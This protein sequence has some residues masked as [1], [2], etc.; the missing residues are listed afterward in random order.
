MDLT[1]LQDAVES[2]RADLDT[3]LKARVPESEAPFAEP[4][5]DTVLAAPLST[6]VVP[7]PPSRDHAKRHRVRYQDKSSA[8]EKE[9]NEVEVAR[10]ISLID[11]ES[12]QL[13]VLEVAAGA[14][15]S[16]ILRM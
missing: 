10:R 13:R 7:L 4:V 8:R 9:R 6:I 11:E 15:S 3:I 1:T 12:C 16:K 2:L 5:E 14:S